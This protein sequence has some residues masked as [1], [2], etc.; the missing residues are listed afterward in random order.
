MLA[1]SSTAY[2]N[3]LFW[4]DGGPAAFAVLASKQHK[5]KRRATNFVFILIGLLD[6]YDQARGSQVKIATMPNTERIAITLQKICNLV[7]LDFLPAAVHGL[8]E[9]PSNCRH[10]MALYQLRGSSLIFG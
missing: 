9:G 7:P 3:A 2:S 10:S 8:F 6:Q 5:M 4:P 1:D